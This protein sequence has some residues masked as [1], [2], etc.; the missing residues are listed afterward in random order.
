MRVGRFR[1]GNRTWYN[2]YYNASHTYNL[3]MNNTD[4]V[5]NLLMAGC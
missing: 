5:T 2:S 4:P 1:R 3:N